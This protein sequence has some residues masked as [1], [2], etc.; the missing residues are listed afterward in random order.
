[1]QREGQEFYMQVYDT[2]HKIFQSIFIG[3]SINS[4][5][6]I[7]KKYLITLKKNEHFKKYIMSYV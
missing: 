4:F 2:Q 1:M 7:L 3:L 5:L 6:K